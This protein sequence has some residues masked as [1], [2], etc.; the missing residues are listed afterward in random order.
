MIDCNVESI[1]FVTNEMLF[2]ATL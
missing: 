1:P 2:M